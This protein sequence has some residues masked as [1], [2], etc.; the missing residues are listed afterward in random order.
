M[1]K[2]LII[3]SIVVLSSIVLTS[4]TLSTGEYRY[5][6]S[7]Q[8]EGEWPAVGVPNSIIYSSN[9]INLGNIAGL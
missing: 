7:D 6:Y 8:N 9:K 5:H 4:C 1:K 2:I 3:I